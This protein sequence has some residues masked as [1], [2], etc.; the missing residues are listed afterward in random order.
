[1]CQIFLPT[2]L[3]VWFCLKFFL[4]AQY[5]R[6]FLFFFENLQRQ[7]IALFFMKKNLLLLL[8]FVLLGGGAWFALKKNQGKTGS[9]QNW[10]MEFAVKDA[11][12][13]Q[14]IFIAD[15]AGKTATLDRK[16]DGT[17]IYN[18]KYKARDG[19]MEILLQTI[20][21]INVN[22][23]PPKAAEKNMIK[24]LVTDAVTVEVYNKK[25]ERIKRYQIGG[26]TNDERGTF[27]IMDGA[28]QPYVVHIPGFVGQLRK[29]FLLGDD[30]WRDRYIF[31]E[32]P[33]EIQSVSVDYPTEKFQSFKLEKTGEAQ[34]SVSPLNPATPVSRQPQRKGFA[35][36]YIIQFE[37]LGAEAFEN[38]HPDRDSIKLNVPFATVSLKKT[39]GEEKTVKFFPMEINLN[40]RGEQYVHRY[41]AETS[42][43][44]FM[45]VQDRVFQGVFRGYGYFFGAPVKN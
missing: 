18:G 35:E 26:V 40:D 38:S 3:V 19:A 39:T 1:M 42:S 31:L 23:I 36:A 6:S 32:K 11:S 24:D 4:P 2:Q 30:E 15:R 41:F 37:K 22:Y 9:T 33:E 43:G 34:F 27:A 10:D 5:L 13:I 14:K 7:K 12:Q 29:R 25:G 17:W 44:D 28:E 45:L 8:F 20:T 16:P 21:R